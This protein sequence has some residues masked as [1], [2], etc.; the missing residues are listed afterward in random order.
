MRGNSSLDHPFCADGNHTG[1][2]DSDDMGEE[3]LQGGFMAYDFRQRK[4]EELSEDSSDID[5]VKEEL[6]EEYLDSMPTPFTKHMSQA[7]FGAC[8]PN[9][10]GKPQE[11]E[12]EM[13]F[14]DC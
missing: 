12:W 9:M 10:Q 4:N 8:H 13:R 14:T 6:D 5:F 1:L 2:T 3:E 7:G 11:K